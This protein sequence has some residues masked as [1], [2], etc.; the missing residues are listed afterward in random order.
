[1]QATKATPPK[2]C[3]RVPNVYKPKPRQ[4]SNI[5]GIPK[6]DTDAHYHEHFSLRQAYRCTPLGYLPNFTTFTLPQHEHYTDNN[7]IHTSPPTRTTTP[8]VNASLN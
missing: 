6:P 4:N 5:Y 1:V 3:S 8:N 2:Q 7:T